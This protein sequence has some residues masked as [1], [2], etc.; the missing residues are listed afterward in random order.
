M[1][2]PLT[3]ALGTSAAVVREGPLRPVDVSTR[4]GIVGRA[5]LLCCTRA[6]ARAVA[7]VLGEAVEMIRGR[8]AHPGSPQQA[9][10]R[11]YALLGVT[12]VVRMALSALDI[13]LW[14]AVAIAARL[15]LVELLGSDR[16]TIAAYDSRGLGLMAPDKLAD[17]ASP[18]DV[19][20]MVDYKQALTPA[21]AVRRG[22]ALQGEGIAW[23][24]E[25]I[26]HDDYRGCAGVARCLDVPVQIGENLNGP[27]A[28]AEAIAAGACDPVTPEVARI[29]GGTGAGRGQCGRASRST[30]AGPRGEPGVAATPRS[31]LRYR[32]GAPCWGISHGDPEFRSGSKAPDRP[33]G[34][35][36]D[37]G[38]LRQAMPSPEAWLALG[39]RRCR[40]RPVRPRTAN[41]PPADLN[42]RYVDGAWCAGQALVAQ[43]GHVWTEDTNAISPYDFELTLHDGS[44][45]HADAK[46]TAGRFG[47]PIHLSLAEIHHA[48]ESGVPYRLYRLYP[49][50]ESEAK[51][52]VAHDVAARLAPLVETL[53]A[54][55]AGV[56]IDS[57]CFD[58][59]F[60][61][62]DATEVAIVY[63][64]EPEE[65]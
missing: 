41:G 28:M 46:S 2:V 27:E 10:P 15:P 42:V 29:G 35:A 13:A 16:R 62:F 64:D 33:H 8:A 3:F 21:E 59:D 14:D 12:G 6:G 20:P 34:P 58:P 57:L 43:Q 32:R 19:Q 51:L 65:E 61:G 63:E 53:N 52:R 25:P 44:T 37:E 60:L 39:V 9:L 45:L 56:R 11:R 18:G 31:T 30:G 23:L 5:H 26:R 55:P 40:Q 48:L 49:V 47:S 1:L 7:T 17:E 22:H 38:P 4:E 36:T 24:E 54:L 50:K